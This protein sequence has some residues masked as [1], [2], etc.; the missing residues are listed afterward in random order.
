MEIIYV[1]WN[2][3]NIKFEPFLFGAYDNNNKISFCEKN[4]ILKTFSNIDC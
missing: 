3:G 1:V 2:R 4:S